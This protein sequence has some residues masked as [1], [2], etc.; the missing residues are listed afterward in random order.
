MIERGRIIRQRVNNWISDFIA[1]AQFMVAVNDQGRVDYALG[2]PN[3]EKR[4]V[5]L[6]QRIDHIQ[7]RMGF[8]EKTHQIPFYNYQLG[9]LYLATGDRQLALSSYEQS[10]L[11]T[12][13]SNPQFST[14][15]QGYTTALRERLGKDIIPPIQRKQRGDMRPALD[16]VLDSTER[17]LDKHPQLEE[18][19]RERIVAVTWL[20]Q[21]SGHSFDRITRD[22]RKKQRT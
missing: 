2:I 15:A 21:V 17:I 22:R 19:G 8:A 18:V 4:K 1:Q 5:A 3:A 9:R 6:G 11:A 20:A 16:E 10:L 14:Y 7:S 12:E 13:A